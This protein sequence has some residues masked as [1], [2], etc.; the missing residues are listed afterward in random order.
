M[1]GGKAFSLS[2]VDDTTLFLAKEEQVFRLLIFRA[3]NRIFP[4]LH[5]YFSIISFPHAVSSRH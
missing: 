2:V 4:F 5:C 3:N 1:G